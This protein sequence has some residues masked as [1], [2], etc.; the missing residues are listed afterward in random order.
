M[1][2]VVY[3]SGRTD[4]TLDWHRRCDSVAASVTMPNTFEYELLNAGVLENPLP[5]RMKGSDVPPQV[6]PGALA[7]LASDLENEELMR[8]CEC[9]AICDTIH[10][11]R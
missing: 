6:S 9:E 4:A 10:I 3:L 11:V 1:K 2:L 7:D 5:V 8:L